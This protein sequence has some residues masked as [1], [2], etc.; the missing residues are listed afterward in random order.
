MERHLLK[1]F[2]L[3]TEDDE[4][5]LE[6]AELFRVSAVLYRTGGPAPGSYSLE[7]C[8]VLDEDSK[9]GKIRLLFGEKVWNRRIR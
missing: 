6:V 1:A 2:V 8:A 3:R 7:D 4:A 9:T 5:D